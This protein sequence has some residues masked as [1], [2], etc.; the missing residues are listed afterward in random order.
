M[1]AEEAHEPTRRNWTS[2]WSLMGLQTQNAFNDKAIQFLLVPL[3]VWLTKEGLSSVPL[4]EAVDGGGRGGLAAYIEYLLA[5]LIVTPFIL[6]APIAG[7]V[8]DR[9]SKQRV[10]QFFAWFQMVVLSIILLAMWLRIFPLAVGGFFLLA[11]QSTFL[12]PAK[13]GIIKELLGSRRLAFASGMMEMFTILA[14]LGGTILMGF[15]FDGRLALSG[16]GW[17]AGFVPVIALTVAAT[18]AIVAAHLIERTPRQGR[19]TWRWTIPLRH[20]EQLAEV[21]RE[22]PLRLSALGVAYFWT[23]GGV[24]QLISVQ[25]S[26]ELYGGEGSGFATALAWMMMA[27]GGGIAVGSVMASLLSKRH[28]ELGLIPVGGII[29]TLAT[30]CLAVADPETMFF[31]ASLA[32]AGFGS[33]F[34]LVPV[35]AFL[36]DTCKPERRGSVLAG[37]NLLNCFFGMLAVGAQLGMK[38][39]GLST[40]MQFLVMAVTVIAATIYVVRLLPRHFLRWVLLSLVRV[41]YRIDVHHADRMPPVGGVVLAPNHV[42]YVDAL[43][44]SAASPRP[45]QFVMA[46]DFFDKALV[47]RVARLFETVPISRTRAKEAIRTAAE[48]VEAGGV[49]CIFPEG[50][51]TRDGMLAELK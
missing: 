15:W 28:I 42:S 9:F 20:F 16:S 22:R 5:G 46:S 27:A 33:A 4:E 3:G 39:L 8:S 19:E 34:F 36:Q 13:L 6:F 48:A 50:S 45:V 44:L 1:P 30:A 23:F 32:G 12:S 37:S 25:I 11:V 24:V 26:R 17:Q 21:L 18:S 41:V 43:I 7:W 38:S 10:I 51:L 49:V 31:F 14:I 35:N 47:G 40:K 2:F 29:M